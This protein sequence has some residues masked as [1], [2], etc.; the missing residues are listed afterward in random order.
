VILCRQIFYSTNNQ[1]GGRIMKKV[2]LFSMILGL[3]IAMGALPSSSMAKDPIK[4]GFFAPLTGFAAQTGRDMLSGVEGY[5]KEAGPEVA[6]RKIELITEDSEAK[7]AVALTKVRKLVEKDGC[8]VVFGGLMASTGYA[9][10]P[11]VDGKK[12]P[13]NYPIMAPDDLTQRHLAHWIIRTGW[14]SSQ[15]SHPFGEY[16]YK[17]LGLRKIVTIGFDYA[18]GW[19]VI[20]GFQQTFEKA[21]GRIIQKLWAPVGTQDYGPFLGKIDKDADAVFALFFGAGALQFVKQFKD[22]GLKDKMMLL[23]GGT[24]T[25]EHV[26]PSMGDEAIGTI[27]ALHYSAALDNPANKAFTKAFRAHAGKSASYYSENAYDGAKWIVESIKAING[28]VENKEKLLDAMKNFRLR[29]APRGDFVLDKFGNPIQNIYIRKVERVNGELQNTVIK[30]YP[31]VSQFWT[32][33]P[34][35]YLKQPLYTRDWPPLQK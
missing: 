18:F 13:T 22:Y 29:D 15:P 33:S 2:F 16:A 1:K 23:G 31:K 17:E 9:L 32:W 21:G 20:G 6:G 24:T 14:T 8:H 34:E 35:E 11:Y 5:M 27:T 19:E 4:L 12:V 7:P 30:T 10:Q 28:E 26:L 3:V 25:D